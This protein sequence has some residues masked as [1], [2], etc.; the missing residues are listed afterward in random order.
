MNPEARIA[1]KKLLCQEEGY[2]QF[3][4]KDTTGH[5]TIG[6][7]RNL[8][9]R[10]IFPSEAIQMLENDIEYFESKI[11]KSLPCYASLDSVRQAVLVDMCFNL[12]VN[13]LLSF[14]KLINAL[15]HNDYDSASD[16]MLNSLWAKQ[17]G[18]R[19]IDLSQAMKSGK[20]PHN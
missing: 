9:A 16:E 1:L 8:E 3:P 18:Q 12:G 13:G 10:G 15:N 19:A 20:L 5:L 4:Y 2:R 6:Y 14:N 11:R 7:G 17:V